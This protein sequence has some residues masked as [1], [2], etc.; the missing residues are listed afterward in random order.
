MSTLEKEVESLFG[1]DS[2]SNVEQASRELDHVKSSGIDI[3]EVEKTS[4]NSDLEKE[5]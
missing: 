5:D 3:E 1:G 2:K 4:S